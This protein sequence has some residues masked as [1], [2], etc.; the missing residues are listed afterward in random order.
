MYSWESADLRY[1]KTSLK[2]VISELRQLFA[3][4]SFYEARQ[5]KRREKAEMLAQTLDNFKLK[6][7]IEKTLM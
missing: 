5:H 7:F 1:H 4:E 3:G 6:C 2:Y